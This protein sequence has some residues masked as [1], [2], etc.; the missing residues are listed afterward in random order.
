VGTL[1][2][3]GSAPDVRIVLGVYDQDNSQMIFMANAKSE[4]VAEIAAHSQAAF[5][6]P[7]FGK[8]D[9]ARVRKATVTKINPTPAQLNLYNS[10]YPQSAQYAAQ[11]AFFALTFKQLISTSMASTRRLMLPTN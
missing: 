8:S 1:T 4:K 7:Q 2:E 6:T 9:F 5:T 10:K 11:S 3:D